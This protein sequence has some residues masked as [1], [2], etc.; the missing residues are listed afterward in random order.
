MVFMYHDLW[1]SYIY[2]YAFTDKR[3]ENRFN[4]SVGE[5]CI[6]KAPY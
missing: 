2:S 4:L 3:Q 6:I 5:H 1:I